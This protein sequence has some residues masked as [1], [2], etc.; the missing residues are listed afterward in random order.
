MPSP[1]ANRFVVFCC[2]TSRGV[3]P[4]GILVCARCDF[5]HDGASVMPNERYAK[6]V[7]K[8][9]DRMWDVP[10]LYEGE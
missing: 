5:N 6:D 1:H 4:G 9:G 2:G 3:F 8:G 7:P 10:R